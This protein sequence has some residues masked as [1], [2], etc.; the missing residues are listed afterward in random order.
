MIAALVPV[1]RLDTAKS[2]LRARLD[3]H[4]RETADPLL[5]APFAP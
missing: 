1:K 4:M 5:G 3:D 2:R